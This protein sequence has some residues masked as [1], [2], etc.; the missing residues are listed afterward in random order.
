MDINLDKLFPSSLS[1]LFLFVLSFLD[2]ALL[3]LLS[4][5]G[6]HLN[7]LEW[8]SPVILSCTVLY[9]VVQLWQNRT[10]LLKYLGYGDDESQCLSVADY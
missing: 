5:L 2:D 8:L 6:F 7:G 10:E 3:L 1:H 9:W 4:R